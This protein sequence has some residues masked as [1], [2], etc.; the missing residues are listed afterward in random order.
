MSNHA[1]A[2]PPVENR[3]LKRLP[4]VERQRIIAQCETLELFMS[5]VLCEQGDRVRHVYFPIDCFLSLITPVDDRV[6]FEVGMVGSEGMQGISLTLGVAIAPQR[7]LV[8]GTGSTLRMTAA[9]FRRELAR[10]VPLQRVLARYLHVLMMQLAQT[11]ACTRFHHIEERL[12][13]WLLMTYDRAPGHQLRM[14]HVF[15]AC[16]LGMRREGITAAAGSLQKRKF[17]RYARGIVTITNRT[18]LEGASCE[19]YR[20]DQDTYAAT[21]GA[22]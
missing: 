22:G 8:Q 7:V 15:L 11:V 16:M 3:L 17:I 1:P 20:I 5:D 18:G 2:K 21:L 12:A 9:A 13:R 10:S 14:T 6:G 19:C 4:R